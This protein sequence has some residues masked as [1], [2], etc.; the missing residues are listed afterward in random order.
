MDLAYSQL[1]EPEGA[2]VQAG[3]EIKTGISRIF[4]KT[5]SLRCTV[6]H[7]PGFAGS[8]L[9]ACCSHMSHQILTWA[10]VLGGG[11]G[12]VSVMIGPTWPPKR[13]LEIPSVRNR[14]SLK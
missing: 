7:W 1:K 12:Y 9:K 13:R 14:P 6:A 2:F 10:E 5:Y 8:F 4:T 11:V 3:K